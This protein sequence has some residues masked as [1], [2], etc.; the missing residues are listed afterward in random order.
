MAT[1]KK[2]TKKLPKKATA[3]TPKKKASKKSAKKAAKKALSK[4]RAPKRST[5]KSE[6]KAAR[7]PASTPTVELS[8]GMMAPL[9]TA[10]DE[11]GTPVSL[12][13]FAGKPVVL[14][15]YPKDDTPGCTKEACDFRDSWSRVQATGA[16][17]LGVSRDSVASHQKFKAKYSL[18]HTLLA[19]VDG[20]LCQS[21]GVWKEKSLY[22]RK[23]MGIERA[24]FVIDGA[25]RIKAVFPKVKVEGH[26][27]E[28]LAA[29]QGT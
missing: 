15:F 20:K 5:P 9:F 1:K 13:Q 22:G 24:T 10:Q 26:V 18:P 7:R 17:V 8:P 4:K 2:S 21:Y 3:K 16:V 29:I 27:D 28:V 11:T 25:G 14:Y 6:K 23:F 12:D 19:D